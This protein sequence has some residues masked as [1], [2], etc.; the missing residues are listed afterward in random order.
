MGDR[1]GQVTDALRLGRATL[2]KVRANLVWALAYNTLGIPL[3]AG[4]LLPSWGVALSPSAAGGMMAFSSVAVVANSLLLRA[5]YGQRATEPAAAAGRS[6][7]PAAA[8]G[9]GAGGTLTA[10]AQRGT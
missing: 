9:S 4:A 6:A 5:Q 3:A 8:V 2:A 7:Q 1:L 10:A